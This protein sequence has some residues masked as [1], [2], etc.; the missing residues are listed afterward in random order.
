V[1]RFPA[2]GDSGAGSEEL[3]R[4]GIAEETVNI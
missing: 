2:G 1:E 4:K 3:M